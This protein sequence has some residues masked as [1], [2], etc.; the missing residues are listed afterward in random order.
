MVF[1]KVQSLVLCNIMKL[2]IIEQFSSP[3]EFD[4]QMYELKKIEQWDRVISQSACKKGVKNH[5]RGTKLV[6]FHYLIS[7]KVGENCSFINYESL[8]AYQLRR[9]HSSNV[10]SYQLFTHLHPPISE[11]EV[12]F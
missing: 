1:P 9:T 5:S 7:S 11:A 10:E 4:A 8:I 6:F 2:L 12:I 3:A